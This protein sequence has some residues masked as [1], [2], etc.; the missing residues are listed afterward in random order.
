MLAGWC[1]KA[2]VEKRCHIHKQAKSLHTSTLSLCL[3]I[4]Q[5]L[6]NRLV[7]LTVTTLQV[8][9]DSFKLPFEGKKKIALIEFYRPVSN[10]GRTICSL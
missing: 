6:L 2:Y 4:A 9:L 1:P 7:S 5:H 10:A 3:A 8:E